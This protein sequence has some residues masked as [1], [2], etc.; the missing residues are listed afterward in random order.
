MQPPQHLV[1]ANTRT[2][3]RVEFSHF[4]LCFV[5][6][7]LTLEHLLLAGQSLK[8]IIHSH[9]KSHSKTDGENTTENEA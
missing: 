4:Q 8:I 3:R 2:A 1:L 9:A 7:Q 6:P 5:P